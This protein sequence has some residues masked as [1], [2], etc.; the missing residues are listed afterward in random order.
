M[1]LVA[2]AVVGCGG[3]S[4]TPARPAAARE[5]E[6]PPAEATE[7]C[8]TRSEATFAGAYKSPRNLVVGPLALVGGAYTDPGTV[9]EF[10]G[11]K[12]PLLVRA[13][14]TV[15]IRVAGA[16][17]LAYGP[18]PEGEIRLR[19]AYRSVTFK[20]CRRR[21][22]TFW[23][24]FVLTPEPACVALDVYIDGSLVPRRAGLALGRRC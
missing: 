24:G 19:D 12:F 21:G 7:N 10:G 13:G 20:A 16:A 23:S 4:S 11:N 9:R 15:T 3:S 18:L 8:S 5:A 1:I 2:I 14:R 17:R 22:T 6:P